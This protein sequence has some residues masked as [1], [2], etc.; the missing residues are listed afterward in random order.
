MNV[1]GNTVAEH[2]W[3]CNACTCRV[4]PGVIIGQDASAEATTGAV[5]LA[6]TAEVVSNDFQVTWSCQFYLDMAML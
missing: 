5:I 4:D 1:I 2:C 3:A 6:D